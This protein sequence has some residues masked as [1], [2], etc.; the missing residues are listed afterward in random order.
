[1]LAED[2]LVVVLL[3]LVG[4]E[5]SLLAET[6]FEVWVV[7]GDAVGGQ[8][9]LDGGFEVFDGGCPFFVVV[10]DGDCVEY[11]IVGFEVVELREVFK[12]KGLD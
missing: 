4:V 9:V 6:L 7:P 3:Y 2:H 1:M 5:R 8:V 10:A 12:E 11:P